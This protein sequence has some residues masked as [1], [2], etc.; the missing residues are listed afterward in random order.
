MKKIRVLNFPMGSSLG[1]MTRYALEN[2]R[3]IDREQYQFDYAAIQKIVE[4][5]VF[6]QY[7]SRFFQIPC[8]PNDNFKE[9]ESN[10]T[11]I[12]KGGY[13]IVHLHTRQWNGFEMEEIAQKNNIKKIIVH[14]HTSD[15][16][17]N[18][19]FNNVDY[20]KK[21]NQLR[22][23]HFEFR[24][25]LSED[26][27]TDFWACSKN[28]AEWLYGD[29]IDKDKIC[30]MQ[31]AIDTKKFEFNEEI[32][33]KIRNELGI[34]DKFVIGHVGRFGPEKNQEF[35]INIL[36]EICKS[37][38]DVC[39]IFIGE[40]PTKKMIQQAVEM[41]GL[42]DKILFLGKRE[43]VNNMLQAMDVFCLPS[44]NEG[45]PIS[46]V[47]A[48][49]ADLACIVNSTVTRETNITGEVIYEDL[50]EDK[51]IKHILSIRKRKKPREN[52]CSYMTEKGYNIV[53][54]I[55]RI[56]NEYKKGMV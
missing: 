15:A 54:Q 29:R 50:N 4:P 46:L 14:A 43:D 7:G 26:I 3:F 42:E 36:F 37:I 56:E 33:S 41:Y 34:E 52:M 8:Y 23:K 11:Q 30:I 32:R 18:I 10:I 22:K 19:D 45:F 51:W 2:G 1:G 39:L 44:L 13:D 16:I 12:L 55:K 20:E 24:D 25:K 40:G 28:A 47:E 38:D 35:L 48:Q 27:A 49:T 6:Q 53:T 9:F 21:Y 17:V 5:N 31:N